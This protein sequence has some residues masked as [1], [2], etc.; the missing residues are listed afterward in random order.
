[1]NAPLGL[2]R[3]GST[4]LHRVRPGAKLLGLVTFAVVVIATDGAGPTLALLGV[5]VVVA[6]MSGL[7]VREL[8]RSLRAFA[9]VAIALFAFQA[10][11]NGVDRG[12]EVVGGLVAL[13]VAATVVT[14]T[15]PTDAMVD[16]IAWAARPWRRL[17]V[18]P[19]RIGLAFALVLAALPRMLELAHETRAA[20][21]ARGLERNPRA[22][23]TP[24]VLRA[25]AH[26]RETGAALHA[27]G[28]GDD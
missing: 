27:R 18:D 2:H 11:Q 10:W 21:R 14:A 15:T 8:G 26:A 7:G 25:V 1:M 9:V 5:A 13:I 16:T 3:P 12:L 17:G 22:Y 4:P 6:L 28:I 23:A 19:D 20:A 24:L